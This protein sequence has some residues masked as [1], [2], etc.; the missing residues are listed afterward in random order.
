MGDK[1]GIFLWWLDRQRRLGT[2]QTLSRRVSLQHL[3]PEANVPL[4]S[5]SRLNYLQD[6][7]DAPGDVR[8][9]YEMYHQTLCILTHEQ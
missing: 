2:M 7:H 1:N 8:R 9:C 3:K 6:L 4:M 5:A